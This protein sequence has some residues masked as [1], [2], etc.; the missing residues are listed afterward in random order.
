MTTLRAAQLKSRISISGRWGE[1]EVFL[2]STPSW[3]PPSLPANLCSGL[4]RCSKVAGFFHFPLSNTRVNKAWIRTSTL[5]YVFMARYLSTNHIY[6]YITLHSTCCAVRSPMSTREAMHV[7]HNTQA[8]LRNH[9]CSGKAITITISEC[10]FYSHSY[11]ACKRM[12]HIF[13]CDLSGCTVFFH[14]I[15]KE[16]KW[17]LSV[18]KCSEVG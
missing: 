5:P 18:N 14:I 10:V 1:A 13:I 17:G 8:R 11:P 12:R 16:F 4:F 7:L 3:V 9:C 2:F 6:P 15:S